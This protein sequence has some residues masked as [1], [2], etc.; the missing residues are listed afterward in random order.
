MNTCDVSCTYVCVTCLHVHVCVCVQGMDLVGAGQTQGS[1]ILARRQSTLIDAVIH[2]TGRRIGGQ[3]GASGHGYQ[4]VRERSKGRGEGWCWGTACDIGVS[5]SGREGTRD[6][7]R[8]GWDFS[9]C[10]SVIISEEKQNQN[11]FLNS[12]IL[13]VEDKRLLLQLSINWFLVLVM[14]S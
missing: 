6:S 12:W 13:L 3:P 9:F 5:S 8:I 4:R 11:D 10:P 7:T 1:E 14:H 2:H